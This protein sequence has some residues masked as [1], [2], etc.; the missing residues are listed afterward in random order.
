M[1][2]RNGI[3]CTGAPEGRNKSATCHLCFTTAKKLIPIKCEIAKKK[4][5]MKEL[6]IVKE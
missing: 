6:V 1:K 5:T 2:I 4:V 3:I